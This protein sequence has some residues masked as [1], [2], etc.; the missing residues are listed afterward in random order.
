MGTTA[1][2]PPATAILG[3]MTLTRGNAP[4]AARP[5]PGNYTIDGPA[6]RLFFE[7]HPRRIR[8]VLAGQTV[9]DT[10]R[11]SLL[12]E[13]NL[14][15]VLYAPLEDFDRALFVDSD[16][17]TH[18]PFKGDATHWSL[19]V[20]ERVAENAVWSYETPLDAAS[21]LAGHAALYWGRADEWWEE[22]DRVLGH[23]RDP[24]A[25]VDV[26]ASARRVEVRLG[27]EVVAASDA[28]RLLFETNLPIRPYIRREEVT[29]G[30]LVPSEKRTICPYKGQATYWSLRVG[31]RLVEDAAWSY[32]AADLLSDGPD[33]AGRVCFDHSEL[34]VALD[35]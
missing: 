19:R 1:S 5:A 31:D 26:H 10:I 3:D 24:Y 9:L 6:H 16:H 20:G 14:L 28:P 8:V 33:I 23:L 29:G 7:A 21:W 35:A 2:R 17:R 25:R 18:C 4:L 15:P 34:E 12:H 30:E 22:D 11:G 27:D 13:S 32:E